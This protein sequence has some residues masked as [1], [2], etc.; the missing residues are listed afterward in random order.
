MDPHVL[1]N[2]RQPLLRDVIREQPF[3]PFGS[4]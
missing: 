2:P 1:L 3:E 4:Q